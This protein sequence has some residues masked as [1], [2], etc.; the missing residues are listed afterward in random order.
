MNKKAITTSTIK[1]MKQQGEPI[2][3][4]TA[5]DVA[6]A[7]NV[8]EAGVEMILVGDS[9][10]NVMLGYGSTV[11]VT[12]EE[13]LHHTKAVMR[14]CGTA[15]VVADM[16]FMSYQASI[17]DGLYNAARFLKETGCTAVK[18]EG[19]SEICDWYKKWLPQAFPWSDTLV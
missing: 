11:P 12:M 6:M 18:L 17:A 14:A 5:Y 8:N 1:A 16:P 4:V 19:G 15:L 2:T 13:M 3:M 9:V 7:R 10:G